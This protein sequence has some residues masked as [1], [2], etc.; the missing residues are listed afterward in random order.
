MRKKTALGFRIMV[1]LC[2][3]LTLIIGQTGASA[4]NNELKTE[5]RYELQP[6]LLSLTPEV[7]LSRKT[8]QGVDGEVSVVRRGLEMTPA[9]HKKLA[10]EYHVKEDDLPYKLYECALM[11]RLGTKTFEVR[12]SQVLQSD[13]GAAQPY[14]SIEQGGFDLMDAVVIP[15]E[16]ASR[17]IIVALLNSMVVNT[18]LLKANAQGDYVEAERST[19][20]QNHWEI[21]DYVVGGQI[22]VAARGAF[23]VTLHHNITDTYGILTDPTK[24]TRITRYWGQALS[25]KQTVWESATD[26]YNSSLFP[27]LVR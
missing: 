21:R 25:R 9:Y 1:G 7:V 19:L 22:E 15:T 26:N 12:R 20:E 3:L 23:R 5:S 16:N 13:F 11:L 4:D 8:L 24:G 6:R 18:S 27:S 10:S 17:P 2:A 14:I